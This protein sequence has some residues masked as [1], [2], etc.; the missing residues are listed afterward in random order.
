MHRVAVDRFAHAARISPAGQPR[1][2]PGV[3]HHDVHQRFGALRIS[4]SRRGVAEQVEQRVGA[5]LLRGPSCQIG[6][7]CF[8][9][10]L[11]VEVT[12]ED[13]RHRVAGDVGEGPFDAP[14]AVEV[15]DDPELAT[16]MLALDPGELDTP[17]L[18]LIALGA[19]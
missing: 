3:A 4:R 1:F 14:D 5:T 13:L 6:V 2:G 11:R 7:G 15:L 16:P 17:M 9:Q 10:A 8:G 12:V 19:D 18:D